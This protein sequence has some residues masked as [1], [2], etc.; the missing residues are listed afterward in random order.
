MGHYD[1]FYENLTREEIQKEIN[2]KSGRLDRIKKESNELSKDLENKL[3][4]TGA[5]L[6]EDQLGK[7]EIKKVILEREIEKTKSLLVSYDKGE[8][9][10][11]EEIPRSSYY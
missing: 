6:L 9:I 3:S 10:T 5:R 7:L 8:K 11:Y 2:E 1:S 4:P